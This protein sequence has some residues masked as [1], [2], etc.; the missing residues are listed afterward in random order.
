MKVWNAQNAG[1]SAVLVADEVDEALITMDSPE[2]E[3]SSAKYIENITIPSALIEKSFG[4][5]LK[6]AISAGEM[7][8]V[9]LD[10]RE[11]VPHTDDRVE[12]EL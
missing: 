6:K 5:K 9:N 12:Y 10:W 3:R 4:E 2:E 1:A 7:V 11:A 8:S